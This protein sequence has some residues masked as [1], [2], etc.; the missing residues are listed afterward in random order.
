MLIEIKLK[1]KPNKVKCVLESP[2]CC[3]PWEKAR[4]RGGFC[5]VASFSQP[6]PSCPP[7]HSARCSPQ[8]VTPPRREELSTSHQ[9][10]AISLLKPDASF[11][12]F[13]PDR[14]SRVFQAGNPGWGGIIVQPS[15][16]GGRLC[17]S[18]I[19]QNRAEGGWLL[20]LAKGRAGEQVDG[21]TQGG[22]SRRVNA[23]P[24]C[25]T[26][27]RTKKDEAEQRAKQQAIST[28]CAATILG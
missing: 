21:S 18:R 8:S 22:P 5:K 14:F 9:T 7:L 13:Y 1:C 16:G 12:S 6:H 10:N 17:K 24:S 4:G 3:L 26:E 28:P 15:G 23:C 2:L 27:P 19:W 25:W 20:S 11:R